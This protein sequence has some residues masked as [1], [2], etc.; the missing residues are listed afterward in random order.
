M[1][2]AGCSHAAGSEIDGTYDSDYNRKL[3]F[4]NQLADKLGYKPIN[5]AITGATNSGIA[6]SVIE[7]Y[8]TSYKE[9]MDLFVLVAWTD[10]IRLEAPSPREC[11][12]DKSNPHVD[13]FGE[14]CKDYFRVHIA[15]TFEKQNDERNLTLDYQGFAVRNENYVEL[16]NANY[17]L[18]SQYFLQSK[19][20]PFLMVNSAFM[21]TRNHRSLKFYKSQFDETRYVNHSDNE[22]SF[23]F[24]YKKA[25][26]TNP[27]AKYRHHGKEAHAD[28]A[29]C[30]KDYIVENNLT[31]MG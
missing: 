20:I 1:L 2:I 30:L 13:W 9:W 5:I 27:K 28:Y 15:E 22:E 18:M 21:F 14:S 17:I 12:Y 29:E 25:G 26:Y 8:N 16:Q 10:G 7:W 6:R 11:Y 3:S 19:K 23:Y 31:I 24:R 4:G